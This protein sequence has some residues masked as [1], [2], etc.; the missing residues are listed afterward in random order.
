MA[1]ARENNF[2]Y[3]FAALLVFL[4][5]LPFLED[6]AAVPDS[7]VQPVS[8]ICL[9]AIGVWSFRDSISAFRLGIGLVVFGTV[10]NIVSWQSESAL[11]SLMALG[12]FAAFLVLAI[13]NA[14]KK[15]IFGQAM[16][17][18]RLVGVVCVYLLLGILWA[19]LYSA[20]YHLD[21][22]AFAG[23]PVDQKADLGITWVY[24][25]FVTLTTLGYGDVLPTSISAKVLAFSEAI[26]GVFYMATLVA[27]LVSAYAAEAADSGDQ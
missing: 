11:L 21:P 7:L 12:P 19:T 26:L 22:T 25:S 16:T 2:Y 10:V 24:Y 13:I 14:L 4:V 1:T 17:T 5:L 20:L 6:F 27:M 9:L 8:I 3:M 18:N 15:V 23:V